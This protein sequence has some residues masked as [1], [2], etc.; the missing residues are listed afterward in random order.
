M[1]TRLRTEETRSY[2]GECGTAVK[3]KKSDRKFKVERV[4]ARCSML[5]Y[6]H[7]HMQMAQSLI[8]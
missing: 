7:V 6:V 4:R 2:S 3:Q 5:F 8:Y 1:A